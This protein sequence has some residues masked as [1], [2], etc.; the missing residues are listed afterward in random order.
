ME[1]R[2]SHVTSEVFQ[3][4]V[5]IDTNGKSDIINYGLQNFAGMSIA[6][7]GEEKMANE[8]VIEFKNLDRFAFDSQILPPPEYVRVHV[9][10]LCQRC[11]QL[12]AQGEGVYRIG[13]HPLGYY[14]SMGMVKCKCCKMHFTQ[15]TLCAQYCVKCVPYTYE[16]VEGTPM[17]C[18]MVVTRLMRQNSEKPPAARMTM[19]AWNERYSY[20]PRPDAN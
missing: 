12:Y 6:G 17:L 16:G 10:A 19:G 20:L 15:P 8:Q 18:H 13:E 4:S 2:N 3:L 11:I 5:T 14:R 9:P 1:I 7:V